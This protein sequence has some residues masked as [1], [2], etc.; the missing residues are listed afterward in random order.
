M[1]NRLLPALLVASAI[2]G[3]ANYRAVSTFAHETSSMTAVL[4]GEFTELATLCVQQA[5]LVLVVNDIDD[6]K[7]LAQCD[8]SRRTQARF[9]SVTVDVL[10]DY[11][12]ALAAL[13]DDR[14]FDLS[15]SVRSTVGKLEA[16][17]DGSGNPVVGAADAD[18]IKRIAALLV[19]VVDTRKRDEAVDRMIRASPDLTVLGSTL[20]AF[21][22]S[23][24][25][26]A[27]KAPYANF[28]AV[29]AGSAIST[30]LLLQSRPMRQAEPIRTA[31]L[32]R[33]LRVRRKLLDQRQSAVPERISAA[34]DAWL[35]ALDRFTVDARKPD[36]LEW[37]ARLEALREAT[38]IAREAVAND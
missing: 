8:A 10:D 23:P 4:K 7:A 35:A 32:L 30:Q 17:K 21:F 19:D 16:L 36:S 12:A 15:P 31:E 27:A 34:I 13:A 6:D 28:V 24:L 38:R 33:A 25:G 29:I 14:N 1:L 9:A 18:A 26:A 11:A 5:E 20:K 22:V 3:C 37:L 2:T